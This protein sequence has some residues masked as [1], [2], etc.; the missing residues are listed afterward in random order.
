MSRMM[1]KCVSMWAME[2][3]KVLVEKYNL[4]E[5]E[6]LSTIM[7]GLELSSSSKEVKEVKK[8]EVKVKEVEFPL[9]FCS[10]LVDRNGC[11]GLSYNNG[12]FTQCKNQK[13][14]ELY[15]NNCETESASSSRGIPNCGTI[16]ERLNEN[17]KD[18]K[19]RKPIH[20]LSVLKKKKL[21]PEQA[22][23]EAGK[24]NILLDDY[25]LQ[26]PVKQVKEKVIKEKVV[27]EKP[28]KVVKEKVVK[29]KPVKVVKEKQVKEKK[30]K[31]GRP[32]S[33]KKAIETAAVE[34]LFA[35]LVAEEVSNASESEAEVVEVVEAVVDSKK[36][37]EKQKK[38]E[39]EELK[40]MQ[41]EETIQKKTEKEQKALQAKAEKEKKALQAKAEKEQ[42]ALQAKAEKEAKEAA[43]KLEKEQKALQA[44]AEKEAKEAAAKLEKEQKASAAKAEKDKKTAEK[45]KK[46]VEKKVE[47]KVE[48]AVTKV[49]VK[50]ITI[51]GK[52]YLKTP[53][54]ILYDPKTKEEVGIY[55]TETGEIDELPEDSDEEEVE[56]DYDSEDN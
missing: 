26:E 36:E 45:D 32:K 4:S 21:T 11:H 38:A 54:N 46:T 27:K 34:D 24:K 14:T 56:D 49:T 20:Y 18:F 37:L 55:N 35:S 43:A 17:F 29:E 12:L 41:G 3:T 5:S 13:K 16:E 50:R 2:A 7:N 42:K 51:K 10:E 9:P 33:T 31:V 52:E 48:E 53:T 40:T 30:E 44:K 25:H 19:N 39:K 28:V 6:C 15:C 1:S 8:K 22:I 23:E 47:E